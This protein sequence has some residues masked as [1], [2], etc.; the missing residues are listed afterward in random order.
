VLFALGGIGGLAIAGWTADLLHAF[1]P[2]FPVPLRFDLRLDFR[3]VGFGL[4]S[5]LLTAL[6][7]GLAPA[8]QASRVDLVAALKNQAAAGP[9]RSRLR[10]LF[11]AGQVALS[12]ALLAGAGL[13]VRT[14]HRARS[15][16]PGFDPEG[17]QTARLDLSLLG[18][19]EAHGRAF[20]RQLVEAV[21][22]APAVE[23]V[24]LTR[25]VPL[26]GTGT[27]VTSVQVEGRA[28]DPVAVGFNVVA[29]RYFETLRL[30]L[31][32]GRDFRATDGPEAPRVAIVNQAFARHFWPN[33]DAVGRR[34]R[35]G[36]AAIEVV[37]VA[38]DSA[39]S[40]PGEAPE[41]HL[42]LPHA[43]SFSPRMTLLA[44]ARGDLAPV[45]AHIRAEVA[46]LEKDLP[47]VESTP[48]TEAVAFALFPQRMLAVVAGALGGLGLVLAGTGLYGVVAYSVSR[49][50]R[51]MGIRVALGARAHDLVAMVLREGLALALMGLLPGLLLAVAAGRLLS[52]MLHGL[53][54]AD[55]V[56]LGAVAALL[57]AVAGVA[58]YLPARRAAR[59]DPMV[60]LRYE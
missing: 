12:V 50:T 54:P 48:L 20:Y 3:V 31:V 15:L 59:V 10:G 28:G 21:Q 23:A 52:S 43:Q 2:S 25:S 49:R 17:V 13:L 53:S 29:P 46:R 27:L 30:P 26:R 16:D 38:R 14:L 57:A 32:A 34:L 18:P 44:R 7:F 19:D 60:A 42:Y 39:Y 11:V 55:P 8:L 51:E 4:G 9:G 41:S 1:Q 24:S 56:A 58:S 22:A 47:V 40:R 36:D 37:G 6:L 5:T 45:A 33:E 35:R